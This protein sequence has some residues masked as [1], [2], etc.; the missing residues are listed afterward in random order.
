MC[1]TA[2]L[3]PCRYCQPPCERASGL[4]VNGEKEEVDFEASLQ[5]STPLS[6]LHLLL[7]IQTHPRPTGPRHDPSRDPGGVARLANFAV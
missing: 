6:F 1:P 2:C 4:D 3:L 5:P 7:L